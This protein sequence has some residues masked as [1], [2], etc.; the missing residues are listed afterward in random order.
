MTVEGNPYVLKNVPMGPATTP[1][2]KSVKVSNVKSERYFNTSEW[3]Y[4]Y[5]TKYKITV[6]LS[7][8]AA[9]TKGIYLTV[10]GTN[11]FTGNR[12][13][14]HNNHHKECAYEPEGQKGKSIRKNL[15]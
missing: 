14:F 3:R 2:I 4:K 9:N 1:V 6:T 12:Q 7:K 13:D 8:K 5:R 11:G 15:Q 10:A